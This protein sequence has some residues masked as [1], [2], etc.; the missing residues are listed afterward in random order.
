MKCNSLDGI[1]Y[2]LSGK[3]KCYAKDLPEQTP[4]LRYIIPLLKIT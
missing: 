4:Y 2:S 1:I 3:K